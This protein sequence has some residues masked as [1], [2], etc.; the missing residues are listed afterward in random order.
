MPWD[1]QRQYLREF[2]VFFPS[3]GIPLEPTS[4]V[5]QQLDLVRAFLQEFPDSTKP[6][7]LSSR[8]IGFKQFYDAAIVTRRL[9]EAVVEM[10]FQPSKEL[11]ERLRKIVIGP[12]TQNL[13]PNS[14][15][16]FLFEL[17]MATSFK[18]AGY[19]VTLREPDLVLK[20]N[21]ISH[22]LGV[23]CK[24]PSSR[25]QIHEHL[26][27]GYKQISRQNLDGFVAIGMDLIVMKEAF[28]PLAPAFL[29]FDQAETSPVDIVQKLM[30]DEMKLL[31]VERARD[32][33]AE[34]I[35]DS[36]LMSLQM[37]GTYQKGFAA[38]TAWSL[39]CED[40]SSLINELRSIK[41]K[42]ETMIIRS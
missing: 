4:E 40:Q 15:K 16:D 22:Q 7:W 41:G 18:Y 2:D 28:G 31:A 39:Q 10:Q 3:L 32:Y 37:W 38:I 5:S 17:E 11:K 14:A 1:K 35:L 42:V 8:G 6:A 19:E 24:Y 26:S 23:A 21:G 36:S 34:H 25:S 13:S 30:S 20:G 29:D 12:L 9:T 33:P 27:K